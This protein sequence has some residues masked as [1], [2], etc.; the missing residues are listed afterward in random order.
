[1]SIAYTA[2][3]EDQSRGFT[4]SEAVRAVDH[5]NMILDEGQEIT[6]WRDSVEQDPQRLRI[7]PANFSIENIGGSD[8]GEVNLRF[9]TVFGVKDH[10]TIADA[11]LRKGD[12]FLYE[13][14]DYEIENVITHPGTIQ[15]RAI[16]YS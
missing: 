7:E 12:L 1:M 9:L 15:A 5:W 16:R 2:W 14:Q 11:D 13:G 10:P 6:I 4:I 8:I 3:L